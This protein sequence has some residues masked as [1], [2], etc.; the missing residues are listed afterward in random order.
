MEIIITTV[1]TSIFTNLI[2]KGG[3]D[4]IK[5]IFD[6][7][8][9]VEFA[10]WDNH[11]DDLKA[12]KLS[13][14]K[15]IE[16]NRKVSAEV[17]SILSISNR[18]EKVKVHLIASDTI[19]SVLAA[20]LIQY[21]FNK[22]KSDIEVLFDRPL[23]K[24]ENQGIIKHVIKKLQVI[25]NEDYQEGFTNLIE[26]VLKVIDENRK[27]GEN[28]ILNIT[29][30]YKAIIPV[31]TLLGQIKK[32]PLNYI[33]E[34]G[35]SNDGPQLVEIGNLPISFDWGII[36]ALKPFL[37][38][39]HLPF[40]TEGR[41]K[42]TKAIYDKRVYYDNRTNSFKAKEG[43]DELE[44]ILESEEKNCRIIK[45]LI[46][47]K[48][49]SKEVEVTALGK[50]FQKVQELEG[51]RG[52]QMEYILYNYFAK[53]QNIKDLKVSDYSATS[54]I[55]LPGVFK[56]SDEILEIREEGKTNNGWREIG[57]VDLSLINNGVCVLGES[58]SFSK[59]LT[60]S[61]AKEG[62][63]YKQQMHARISR[64]I[65]LFPNKIY[66]KNPCVEFLIIIYQFQFN[67]FET[68]ILKNEKVKEIISKFKELENQKIGLGKLSLEP[69]ISFLGLRCVIDLKLSNKDLS[70]NY[71]SFYQNPTFEW[72]ILE[73]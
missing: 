46:D 50:L 17:T 24:F 41:K 10:K 69:K 35:H 33:Y 62:R 65:D 57:D 3:K 72:E 6:C 40:W 16:N 12:L 25:S 2:E 30:G 20:E 68:E 73:P 66:T 21:W 60:Y 13:T 9:Q 32:V 28:V 58:K 34:E 36:D 64:F 14:E 11:E 5:E 44:I 26:I 51:R 42:L 71:M 43:E 7:L 54:P 29:G 38:I 56:F 47:L 31:I 23:E 1:G 55:D 59:F 53:S 49:I 19:L 8:K 67:G 4:D 15:A 70:A 63:K 18:Y 48:L 61:K 39:Q 45:S 27:N 22:N 37:N 52:L